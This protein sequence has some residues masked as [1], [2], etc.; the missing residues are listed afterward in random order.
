VSALPPEIGGAALD[1]PKRERLL[2]ARR[3]WPEVKAAIEGGRLVALLPV[4]ATEAH[5]PHLALDTDVAIAEETC[6]RAAVALEALGLR[7]LVLPP[8]AYSVTRFAGDFA[9]TVGI[10]EMTARALW[11]DLFASL[12]AQGVTRLAVV[13]HHLEPGHLKLLREAVAVAPDSLQVAFPDHTRRPFPAM[14]GDEFRSGDCHAGRYESAL[15]LAAPGAD[16]RVREPSRAALPP[17][18]VGLVAAIKAG[19]TTF[20]EIGAVEAYTGDPRAATAAEG[21]AL[22]ETLAKIVVDAVVKLA[23]SAGET[24]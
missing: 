13:N 8:V 5:G 4:G 14:L 23:P 2:W 6:L 10:T 17:R 3:T 9:G 20:R 12:A 15:V 7:A 21:D 22:Y 18:D 1:A 19:K 24:P 11:D 16:E